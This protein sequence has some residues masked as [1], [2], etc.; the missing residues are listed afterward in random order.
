MKTRSLAF[1]PA[2]IRDPVDSVLAEEALAVDDDGGYAGALQSL[3]IGEGGP[4]LLSRAGFG[5]FRHQT[6]GIEAGA[7]RRPLDRRRLV[8]VEAC[9]PGCLE[10]GLVKEV[11]LI[12]IS[13]V[14]GARGNSSRSY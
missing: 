8:D 3:E 14:K 9:D 2:N 10:Q 4:H 12:C 11:A 13:R 6:L 5:Q 7:F 1:C